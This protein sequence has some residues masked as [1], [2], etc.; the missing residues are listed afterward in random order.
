MDSKKER[1]M[2]ISSWPWVTVTLFCLAAAASAQTTPVANAGPDV[3]VGCVGQT[4][5]P[6]NLDGTGSSVGPEFTYAWTA[7]GVTFSSADTLTPVGTFPVGTTEATLTVT[8]TD[9]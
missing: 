6:L 8:S 5:T 7:P 3:T 4:G 2:R 1:T 9:P